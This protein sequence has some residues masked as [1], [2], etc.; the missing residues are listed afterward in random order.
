M[1]DGVVCCDGFGLW[2]LL[3]GV[4][5]VLVGGVLVLWVLWVVCLSV[6]SGGVGLLVASWCEFLLIV[7]GGVWGFT[8][9]GVLRRGC[10]VLW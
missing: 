1:L 6:W 2:W 9:L 5:K 3:F 8:V 4:V 7:L 10:G